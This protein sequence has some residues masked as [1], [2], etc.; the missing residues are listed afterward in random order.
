MF[1]NK[2]LAALATPQPIKENLATIIA[3]HTETFPHATLDGQIKKFEEEMDEYLSAS[4][5]TNRLEELADLIIVCCGIARFNTATAMRHIAQLP[6][7]FSA[8]EI[9]TALYDKMRINRQRKWTKSDG[10]YRHVD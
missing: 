10:Q 4:T 7:N 5:L 2:N 8:D 1:Q 9:N 3:W 6:F